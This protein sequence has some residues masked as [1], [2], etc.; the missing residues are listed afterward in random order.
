EADLRPPRA[1]EADLCPP[2]AGEAD[3]CPPR[4]K[5]ADLRPPRAKRRICACHEPEREADLCARH[6]PERRICAATSREADLRPPRSQR[7]G[8]V[9]ATEPGRWFCARHEPERWIC[10]RHEPE[11][12]ICARHEPTTKNGG[13][14]WLRALRRLQA[15]P[16]EPTSDNMDSPKSVS[17]DAIMT[18]SVNPTNAEEIKRLLKAKGPMAI[19]FD[20]HDSFM[21]SKEHKDP[22][23]AYND[24]NV[25]RQD[26][27][28]GHAAVLS[29][30]GEYTD[31]D[32]DTQTFWVIENSWGEKW[33]DFGYCYWDA[34]LDWADVKVSV[35][36]WKDDNN[37]Y[38]WVNYP[39]SLNAR[40]RLLNE[41]PE[42]RSRSAS[43]DPVVRPVNKLRRALLQSEA[44]FNPD[45]ANAESFPVHA[46]LEVEDDEAAGDIEKEVGDLHPGNCSLGMWNETLDSLK[47]EVEKILDRTIN[48]GFTYDCSSQITNNTVQHRFT[49]KATIE[50]YAENEYTFYG[51]QVNETFYVNSAY[52]GCDEDMCT[53][54]ETSYSLA[55]FEVF[56]ARTYA[57]TISNAESPAS[58]APPDDSSARA[59]KFVWPALIM[60]GVVAVYGLWHL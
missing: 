30:Y 13:V 26:S 1:R 38:E 58:G 4:A 46:V 36:Y 14:I 59:T 40:R 50:G 49:V 44:E 24:S 56:E 51:Q 19:R 15:T 41:I 57:N 11:R 53:I 23:T 3:L 33:A 47:A 5:E 34:D 32:G 17:K 6:E 60:S 28:G 8:S 25:N 42:E 22:V 7:G 21:N 31:G 48:I 55:G 12:R 35:Q 27:L 20:V 10:A 2:R 54:N 16:R 37:N 52:D 45:A 18:L 9:P 39:D 29:G 43:W